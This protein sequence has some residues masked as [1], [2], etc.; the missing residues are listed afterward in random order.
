MGVQA[1]LQ[2]AARMMTASKTPRASQQKD[3]TRTGEQPNRTRI[4]EAEDMVILCKPDRE[5]SIAS[6]RL[7]SATSNHSHVHREEYLLQPVRHGNTLCTTSMQ[8]CS[9]M[10]VP[11]IP[12]RRPNSALDTRDSF[13]DVRSSATLNSYHVRSWGCTFPPSMVLL[14]AR[15][16]STPHKLAQK[17]VVAQ[18]YSLFTRAGISPLPCQAVTPL[19]DS[20]HDSCH[21]HAHHPALPLSLVDGSRA[22][23]VGQARSPS[24]YH[25]VVR[26]MLKE[27][28]TA[29]LAH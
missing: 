5:M 7:S 1:L 11:R 13:I 4:C 29:R 23:R 8:H 26:A 22:V 19:Q 12:E 25:P 3:N 20:P 17:V 9:H 6:R 15:I 27:Q 14:L 28:T 16:S 2:C 18:Q 24:R 21:R 10:A